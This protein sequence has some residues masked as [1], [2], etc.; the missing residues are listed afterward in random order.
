MDG[1]R[2]GLLRLLT[3]AR[4]LIPFFINP[5]GLGILGVLILALRRE[6]RP[7][8]TTLGVTT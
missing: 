8:P 6:C 4:F 2:E 5:H 1:A 7:Y 3:L